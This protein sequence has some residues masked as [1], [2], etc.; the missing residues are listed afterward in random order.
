[1]II[2]AKTMWTS[3][4]FVSSTLMGQGCVLMMA[5]SSRTSSFKRFAGTI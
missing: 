1:L 3:V 5:V 4:L 2:T